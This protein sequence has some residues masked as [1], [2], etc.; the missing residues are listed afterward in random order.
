MS[1]T[2]FEDVGPLRKIIMIK[3]IE[4]TG[5]SMGTYFCGCVPMKFAALILSVNL[6][7]HQIN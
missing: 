5:D 2:Y 7:I 6:V 4:A 3:T 1:P